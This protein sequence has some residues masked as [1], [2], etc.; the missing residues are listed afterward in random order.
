MEKILIICH[1]G[2]QKRLITA[3]PLVFQSKK[4][5]DY[6]EEMDHAVF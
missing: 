2:S 6:Y 5:G 3:S 1:A 4:T